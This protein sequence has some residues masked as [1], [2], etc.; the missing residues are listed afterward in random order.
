MWQ[1]RLLPLLVGPSD[2]LTKTMPEAAKQLQL[3]ALH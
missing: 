3:E 1:V 2:T